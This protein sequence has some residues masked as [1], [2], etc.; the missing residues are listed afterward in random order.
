[1]R[2]VKVACLAVLMTVTV[3]V[4]A[5]A[6]EEDGEENEQARPKRASTSAGLPWRRQ[7]DCTSTG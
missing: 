2:G 5:G 1:M 7:R 3:A 6:E 4:V